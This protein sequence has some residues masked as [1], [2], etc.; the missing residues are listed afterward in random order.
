MN[1]FELVYDRGRVAVRSREPL[2]DLLQAILNQIQ[3]AAER[4][5]EHTRR[6]KPADEHDDDRKPDP[7]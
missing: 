2:F 3:S 1:E 5:I 7:E 4:P 6:D